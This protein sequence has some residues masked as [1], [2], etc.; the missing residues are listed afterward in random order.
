MA[1]LI[2]F[3]PSNMGLGKIKNNVITF[4]GGFVIQLRS[5]NIIESCLLSATE[6][7]SYCW[8]YCFLMELISILSMDSE[9]F[10]KYRKVF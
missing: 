9:C 1:Y 8:I 5:Q 2:L 10:L 3:N 7:K 6:I 4:E